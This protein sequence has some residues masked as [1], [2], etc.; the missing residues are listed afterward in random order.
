MADDERAD[1]LEALRAE[2]PATSFVDDPDTI[3]VRSVDA[4]FI[5][6]EGRPLV[7]IAP[8]GTE[9][10]S[11]VLRIANARGIPSSRRAA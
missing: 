5:P 7:L 6:P 9:E 10:V 3:A 4:S 1:A 2:L 8:A 11:A